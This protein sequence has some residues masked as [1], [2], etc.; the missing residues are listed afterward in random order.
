MIKLNSGPSLN[1][2]FETTL[3]HPEQTLTNSVA[4]VINH[5]KG[6]VIKKVL[7]ICTNVAGQGPRIQPDFDSR[8]VGVNGTFNYHEF[9]NATNLNS[10]TLNLYRQTIGSGPF[11]FTIELYA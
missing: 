10:I 3:S 7:C 8:V 4:Y 5:N 1:K 2:V 9:S 6:V 11:Q